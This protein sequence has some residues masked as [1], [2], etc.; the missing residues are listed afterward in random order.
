MSIEE[1]REY[2]EAADKL[3]GECLNDDGSECAKC[4]ERIEDRG[5]EVFPDGSNEILRFCDG[6]EPTDVPHR[7]EFRVCRRC[8]MPMN[9][10]FTDEGNDMGYSFLCCEECF[11]AEFFEHYGNMRITTDNDGCG[12]YYMWYDEREQE[13]CGTG[14]Y[15]TDWF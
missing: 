12:G 2:E 8:G 6:C 3:C 14:V 11:D 7:H 10:G 1:L 15:W 9:S 13:W 4:G 5:W